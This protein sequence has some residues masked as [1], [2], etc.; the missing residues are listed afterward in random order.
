MLGHEPRD[1]GQ[2][3]EGAGPRTPHLLTLLS[4]SDMSFDNTLF[5]ISTVSRRLSSLLMTK[6]LGGM[7]WGHREP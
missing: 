3:W 1:Y 2:G 4:V 5:A 7:E 6:Q